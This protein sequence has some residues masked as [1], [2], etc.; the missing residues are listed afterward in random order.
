[1]GASRPCKILSTIVFGELCALK[2]ILC[3]LLV[4]ELG[5]GRK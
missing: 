3:K 2:L 5:A 1:M 4:S